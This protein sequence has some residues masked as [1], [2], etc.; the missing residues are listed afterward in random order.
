MAK[1]IYYVDKK[2]LFNNVVLYRNNRLCYIEN[3]DILK[4]NIFNTKIYN[5]LSIFIYFYNVYVYILYKITKYPF[6]PNVIVNDIIKIAKGFV[7]R[8]LYAQRTYKED[9]VNSAVENCIRYLHNFDPDKSDNPF[10]YFTQIVYNSFLRTI[11]NENN[12]RNIETKYKEEMEYNIFFN[13]MD[14]SDEN[15]QSLKDSIELK[16]R[17]QNKDNYI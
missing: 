1:K 4:S 17:N 8:P 5:S 6:V 16:C 9:L 13:V 7:K 15:Y 14:A 3:L 11:L 10:S 12:Q 2:Q